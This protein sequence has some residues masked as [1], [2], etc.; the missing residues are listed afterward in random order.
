M[1]KGLKIGLG[2]GLL[3]LIIGALYFVF[4]SSTSWKEYQNGDITGTDIESQPSGTVD[5]DKAYAIKIG[6]KSF[7]RNSGRTYF[8]SGTGPVITGTTGNYMLYILT[9]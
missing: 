2:I 4:K 3:L 5:A 9:A 8:K 6:A 1:T 7:V